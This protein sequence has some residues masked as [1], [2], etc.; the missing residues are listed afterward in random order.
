MNERIEGEELVA[1]FAG[2]FSRETVVECLR[3]TA[4][5]WADAPIQMYVGLL[6]ERF[7]RERLRAAAQTA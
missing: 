2:T 1:E 6:T 7:A 4:K 5:Q 3:D